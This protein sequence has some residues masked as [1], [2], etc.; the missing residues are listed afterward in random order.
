M[1]IDSITSTPLMDGTKDM[2]RSQA[3]KNDVLLSQNK[4]KSLKIT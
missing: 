3:K 1:V 4:I 2:W